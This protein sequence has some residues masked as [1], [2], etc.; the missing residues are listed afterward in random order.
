M[1]YERKLKVMI[2]DLEKLPEIALSLI[3]SRLSPRDLLSL[4]LVCSRIKQIVDLDSTWGPI[5]QRS[6]N[7]PMRRKYYIDPLVTLSTAENIKGQYMHQ[8]TSRRMKYQVKERGEQA[9][10]HD[11]SQILEVL[12]KVPKNQKLVTFPSL[13]KQ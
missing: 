7:A 9:K 4:S 5:F 8:Y 3:F 2:G 1:V 6:F 12:E 11:H 13:F 10:I